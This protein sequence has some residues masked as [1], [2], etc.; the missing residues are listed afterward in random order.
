MTEVVLR[1]ATQEDTELIFSWRNEPK[2]REHFFDPK[3][4]AS[5]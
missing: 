5:H 3:S 1:E 4:P 2:T